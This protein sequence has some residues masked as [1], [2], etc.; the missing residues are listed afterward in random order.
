MSFKGDIVPDSF[1]TS[2]DCFTFFKGMFSG[3]YYQVISNSENKAIINYVQNDSSGSGYNKV[4]QKWELVGVDIPQYS[5]EAN[6]QSSTATFSIIPKYCKM[7][8]VEDGTAPSYFTVLASSIEAGTETVNINAHDFLLSGKLNLNGVT[9][10]M[11]YNSTSVVL[12]KPVLNALYPDALPGLKVICVDIQ[13]CYEKINGS[14][15][16]AYDMYLVS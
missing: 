2:S 7:E 13:V 3:A 8:V 5:L 15:W 9:L 16:V 12:S 14:D 4:A 10:A 6:N 1:I 11:E